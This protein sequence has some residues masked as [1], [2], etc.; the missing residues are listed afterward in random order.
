MYIKGEFAWL[1]NYNALKENT[2]ILREKSGN[3]CA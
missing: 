3:H 1:I 2:E